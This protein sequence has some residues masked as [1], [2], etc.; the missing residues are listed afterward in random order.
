MPSLP[1]SLCRAFQQEHKYMTTGLV[2]SGS[3]MCSSAI[4]KILILS[5]L[6]VVISCFV[7]FFFIIILIIFYQNQ[8]FLLVRFY[9]CKIRLKKTYWSNIFIF[10]YYLQT[11]R[12]Q[13]CSILI[14]FLLPPSF[15]LFLTSQPSLQKRNN[16]TYYY[17]SLYVSLCMYINYIMYYY[18]ILY[19]A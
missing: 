3:Q 8:R 6:E 9:K 17:V 7:Q 1:W 4:R 14:R 13:K 18:A 12:C 11:K 10:Q 16:T 2:F 15:Q 19:Y 5:S